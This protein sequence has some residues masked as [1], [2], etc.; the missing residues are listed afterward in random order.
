MQSTNYGGIADKVYNQCRNNIVSQKSKEDREI[1]AKFVLYPPVTDMVK[2]RNLC[3]NSCKSIFKEQSRMFLFR[4]RESMFL[5]PLMYIYLSDP[6]GYVKPF[7]L[8]FFAVCHFCLFFEVPESRKSLINMGFFGMI[9][10]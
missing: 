9:S 1:K 10:F 4:A 6:F 3:P 2:D 7:W 8:V 5:F